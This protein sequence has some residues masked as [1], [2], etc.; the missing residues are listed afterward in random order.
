MQHLQLLAE[1][2]EVV[3]RARRT[4]PCLLRVWRW[5]NMAE[6]AGKCSGD[7]GKEMAKPVFLTTVS[8]WFR[9]VC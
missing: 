1:K 2:D 8:P 7:S 9:F 6:R 4:V 5:K 3:Q